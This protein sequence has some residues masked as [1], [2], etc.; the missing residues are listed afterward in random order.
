MKILSVNNSSDIYGASRCLLRLMRRFVAAGHQV[1]VVLP[2]DGPLRGLL[3]SEGIQVHL[4]PRL[5][6]LDRASFSSPVGMLRFL[7]AMPASSL[8]LMR[9]ISKHHIDLVHTNTAVL[10]SP[11]IAARLSGRPHVWHIR[12]FFSEFGS[13]WKIFERFMISFS[14]TVISISQ[15]VRDQF[16]PALREKI[17]VI[18]DGLEQD[19]H[20]HLAEQAAA[21]RARFAS[22]EVLIGVIGRIKWHRKG[23]EVLVKAAGML[24]ERYPQ[25]HYVIIGTS[26]PE[27]MDHTTRLK[28]LI[29]DLNL[30]DRITFAGEIE[31][32]S[33]VQAAL[34][35][36]VVPSIQAEPF[37]MVVIESMA[38]RTAVVG[39]RCGGIEEQIVDGIS[40][41]LF[42]PGDE[43]AL[44]IAL[45]RLIL[46]P[47]TRRQIA[48]A[49]YQRVQQHFLMDR[50]FTETETLFAHICGQQPSTQL[51]PTTT[52]PASR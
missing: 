32:I 7:Y 33:P 34:D 4:C 46:Q 14:H 40:G 19:E 29:S 13:V 20:P 51:H 44:A 9:V 49:G 36:S 27:N 3:E 1:H 11:A 50:T 35:I 38:M 37:G 30:Q 52:E 5:A 17:T 25:V 6:V 43:T 31:D 22:H 41:L 16:N 47:E 2:A 12:E 21:F 15:S 18:Y 8:W 45:E 39:S 48:E 10:P 23:Q 28:A 26:T 24:R 42:P